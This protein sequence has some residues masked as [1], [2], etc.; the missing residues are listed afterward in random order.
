MFGNDRNDMRGSRGEFL[1]VLVLFFFFGGNDGRP[2]VERPAKR[3]PA[4]LPSLGQHRPTRKGA[5]ADERQ[6]PAPVSQLRSQARLGICCCRRQASGDVVMCPTPK[7]GLV[8]PASI[9]PSYKSREAGPVGRAREGVAERGNSCQFIC[10]S[11][12]N[13][14][15]QLWNL[16]PEVPCNCCSQPS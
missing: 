3:P 14:S 13:P 6:L 5:L 7:P 11:V 4:P 15:E 1:A 12:R 8:L 2:S 10:R 9:Y 16:R